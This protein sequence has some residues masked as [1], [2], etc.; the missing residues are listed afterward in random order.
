MLEEESETAARKE[1]RKEDAIK[2]G[3]KQS[4]GIRPKINKGKPDRTTKPTA[5]GPT[6]GRQQKQMKPDEAATRAGMWSWPAKAWAGI[7]GRSKG[8]GR[9]RVPWSQRLEPTR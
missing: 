8:K 7:G 5:S 2:I 6:E 1:G 9:R 4:S 3:S